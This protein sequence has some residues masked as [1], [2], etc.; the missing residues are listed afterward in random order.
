MEKWPVAGCND[1]LPG[2]RPSNI[3]TRAVYFEG[4]LALFQVS[5][6]P[7]VLDYATT[8][9]T[10]HDWG[11]R[12]GDKTTNA[13]DQC[14]AQSYIE[15]YQINPTQESRLTHVLANV[16]DWTGSPKVD[17]YTWIDA[18]Q[19]SMPVFARL[20]AL[21]K[22]KAYLD[23]MHLLY[24]HSK[25]TLGLYNSVDHLWWRDA[26]FKP[27]FVTPNGKQCY[28]SRGNGWVLAA[29]ARVLDVLPKTD[30]HFSGYLQ[31]FKEMSEA[32]KNAQRSDGFWNV[33]LA[34]PN[35]FGGPESSGTAL[36]TY[37]MAW[38]INKGH[39]PAATYLPVVT[40]AWNGLI[41][42]ALH[43]DG[44]LGY[45]QGTGSKPADGQPVG[46]DA[47]PDFDDFGLGAFLLAGSQMHALAPAGPSA[48]K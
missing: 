47:T 13:D 22:N 11:F 30:P 44:L 7:A 6:D 21:K 35:D 17:Y 36:F 42:T 41:H 38:G 27:P 43:P 39:L 4:A 16:D 15:L 45:V 48:V 1:C 46:Y 5:H 40:K 26:K 14:A 8:W 33:S 23:K 3:W 20:G 19:M 10:F 32:L 28:W 29:L 2:S 31:T 24:E 34:D 18:I 25:T 12:K 37:G 9:A